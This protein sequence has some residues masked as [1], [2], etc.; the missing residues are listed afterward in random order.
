MSGGYG[1]GDSVLTAIALQVQERS[2]DHLHVNLNYFSHL[3]I[4]SS[5]I[6][7]GLPL[8]LESHWLFQQSQS[9]SGENFLLPTASKSHMK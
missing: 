5:L 4:H 6:S 8:S 1:P 3:L 2:L 9:V 7:S